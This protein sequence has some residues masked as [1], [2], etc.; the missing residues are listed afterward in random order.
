MLD[1]YTV[2]ECPNCHENLTRISATGE[3]Q[4][5]CTLKNEGG[6]Q[7]GLDIL[8]LLTEE[9]YLRAYPEERKSQAFLNF[10]G[11]GDIEAIVDLLN[12]EH[13]DVQSQIAILLYQDQIRTMKSGLHVAIQNQKI[14]V[15]WLL[16]LLASSL[17]PSDFPAEVIRAAE[18]MGVQRQ[19]LDGKA[20]IR[21][22]E[23]GE[24]KTAE[25]G[26]VAM[27]GIWDEWVRSGRLRPDV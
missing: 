19:N 3:Q 20:D 14:E 9:T 1:N 23:D 4:I 11:D 8:P 25:Q 6:L 27:G 16:L 2:T 17:D 26:A 15:A 10:C 7:E 21:T 13:E 24:G 22:L 18:A 12:D 5:L